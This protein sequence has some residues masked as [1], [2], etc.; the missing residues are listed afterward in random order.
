MSYQEIVEGIKTLNLNQKYTNPNH[1]I[2]MVNFFYDLHKSGKLDLG[3]VRKAI[4]ILT[5][6]YS[7]DMKGYLENIAYYVSLIRF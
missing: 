7:K 3:E 6:E 5:N 2:K 1:D 4:E